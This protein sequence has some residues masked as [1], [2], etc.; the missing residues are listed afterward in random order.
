MGGARKRAHVAVT[1]RKISIRKYLGTGQRKLKP[2]MLGLRACGGTAPASVP[3]LVR[4]RLARRA[5]STDYDAATVSAACSASSSLEELAAERKGL[6]PFFCGTLSNGCGQ[7]SR[8]PAVP[9]AVSRSAPLLCSLCLILWHT[10]TRRRRH[11][12]PSSAVAMA[13]ASCLLKCPA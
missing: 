3:A 9:R 12:G 5:S 13:M 6:V 7:P 8:A 2:A 4:A 11:G 1:A 10:M